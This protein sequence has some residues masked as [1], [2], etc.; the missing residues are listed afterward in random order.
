M[1]ATV[2]VQLNVSVGNDVAVTMGSGF[3]G[4]TINGSIA[5]QAPEMD[6]IYAETLSLAAGTLTLDLVAL[7]R[8]GQAI[9]NLT[10]KRVFG[11]C[12]KNLG[13]AQMTFIEAATTGYGLFGPTGGTEVLPG[14]VAYN[15]APA[16][17]GTVAAGAKNVTI[18][19]TGTQQFQLI[20]WAGPIA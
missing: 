6:S 5:M 10:N 1:P 12:V 18:T 14:G 3:A 17:F 15:Y 16:G 13:A 20:L 11:W 8:G 2:S 9:L 7:A 4:G 19:G